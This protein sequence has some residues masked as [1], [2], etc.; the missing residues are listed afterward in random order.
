MEQFIERLPL[1]TE[2]KAQKVLRLC[3]QRDMQDQGVGRDAVSSTHL[4]AD[5]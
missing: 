4:P 1:E 2:K 3:E 5:I